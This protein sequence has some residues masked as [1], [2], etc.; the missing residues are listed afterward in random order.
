[1]RL[2]KN[3]QSRHMADISDD[4]FEFCVQNRLRLDCDDVPDSW[5]VL[6]GGKPVGRISGVSL[7]EVKALCKT[8]SEPT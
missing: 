2:K 8:D 3:F 6:R 5:I 4:V 1:M 7:Q